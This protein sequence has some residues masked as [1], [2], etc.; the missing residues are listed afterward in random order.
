MNFRRWKV[1]VKPQA[2]TI[3]ITGECDVVLISTGR[4]ATALRKARCPPPR[5]S[6]THK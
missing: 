1:Y 2:M 3:E 5:F 4:D 6:A